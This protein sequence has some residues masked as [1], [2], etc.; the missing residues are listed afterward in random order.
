MEQTF[1]RLREDSYI[2]V[3]SPQQIF[4][5][6]DTATNIQS[7]NSKT[8]NRNTS[9]FNSTSLNSSSAMELPNTPT[10]TYH[11]AT[12]PALD[13]TRPELS[14]KGKS[15]VITGGGTG[16]GAETAKYFAKAGASLIALLGRRE[17]PL[18]TTRLHHLGRG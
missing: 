3:S 4:L 18:V 14:A 2:K 9:H 17:E 15:I 13:P 1:L 16:I 7:S 12:Y 6:S 10:K 5:H 8:Q 11:K